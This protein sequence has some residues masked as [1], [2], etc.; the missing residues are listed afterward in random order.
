MIF[1]RTKSILNKIL[2]NYTLLFEQWKKD[3]SMMVR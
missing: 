3:I 2:D 1:K